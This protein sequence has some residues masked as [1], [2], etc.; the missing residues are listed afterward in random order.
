M[1]TNTLISF[2][3]LAAVLNEYGAAV[4]EAYIQELR[5]RGK[6]TEHD[7]PNSLSRNIHVIV[8]GGGDLFGGA[9]AEVL[10]ELPAHWYN[11]EYG[12]KPCPPSK[13][14]VPVEALI[15]WIRVKPV[16]PYPDKNG[17]IP[18][19]RQLAFLINRA[20]NDP[21]RSGGDPPRPGIAP[22][23]VMQ[24]AVDSVNAKYDTLIKAAVSRDLNVFLKSIS[25]SEFDTRGAGRSAVV[26]GPHRSHKK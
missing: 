15:K 24:S 1:E 25:F 13:H 8:N 16:I 12:R 2:E 7:H 6:D 3:H 5:L 17:N 4:K 20:I 18:T 23:P 14:W 11:V 22:A 21:D 9:S 19:E 26:K 10:L